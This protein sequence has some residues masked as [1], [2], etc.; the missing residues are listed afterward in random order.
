MTDILLT[1][2]SGF[3][4]RHVLPVL[5][6]R[7]GADAVVPVSSS[8]YD[9]TDSAAAV[10]MLEDVK[11]RVVV[12]LAAYSGGILANRT[13]PADFYFRNTVMTALVFEAAA[14][15]D[16]EKF[17]Y[18]FGGCSYPAGASSPIGENQL[19]AGYPQAESAAYSTAKMMGAVA[20]RAYR[21]QYGM[22]TSLMI[23]G[24][25]YG[26]YDN[27]HPEHSHVI[28]ALIRRFHEA[29]LGNKASVTMWGSG[30][31]ERDFVYAGDVAE[32]VPF[33]IDTYDDD[34]PVNLSTAKRTSISD[35]SVLVASL[36]GF[37][38]GLEWDTSKPDGQ[39]VKIF[40]NARMK[41]LGLSCETDLRSG[42]VATIA[43][44]RQHYDAGSGGLRL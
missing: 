42:L 5:Q 18:P 35:L 20:A 40:D 10:R 9:L 19:W 28:P 27:F 41:A 11:P 44:F 39:M 14:R 21:A 1:G 29:R 23:P 17:V 30:A 15:R 34:E 33:F 2:A 31:P 22:R 4:G 37:Q 36:T 38:G 24:H 6:R 8:D 25:I 3:L 16:V 12:H 43:W 13:F 7:Y 32:T 26:E